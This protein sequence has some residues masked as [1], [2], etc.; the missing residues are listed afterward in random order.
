MARVFNNPVAS[1]GH[2][3]TIADFEPVSLTADDIL[4]HSLSE[5]MPAW[6]HIAPVYLELNQG[7]FTTQNSLIVFPEISLLLD[8]SGLAICCTCAASGLKLCEH[9][10]QVL[11]ALVSRDEYRIFFDKFLRT[12]KFRET[13]ADYGLENELDLDSFFRLEYLQRKLTVLPRQASIL[14]VTAESL[15]AL[16]KHVLAS[17]VVDTKPVALGAL[18]VVFRQHKYYRHL[19][20]E[21]FRAEHTKEGK[22]KNPLLPVL[23][24]DLIWDENDA[25][26]V[27]F[28][29]A[30][31]RFQSPV[32]GEHG[33]TDLAALRA[34]VINPQNLPLY[35]H[36]PDISENTV[37]SSLVPLNISLA[38]IDLQVTVQE[39]SP[40][41]ELGASITIQ[42]I[43]YSLNEVSI[44]FSWFLVAGGRFY[45]IPN[46]ELAAV[47]SLFKKR[48][49]N[50]LVHNSRYRDFKAQILLPLEDKV[51][52]EYTDIKPATQLQLDAYGF[53][54]KPEKII[55]LSDFGDEVMLIPVMRYGEVEISVRTRRQ[56][57]ETDA[58]GTE[59][60]VQRNSEAELTFTSV[61]IRQH[62]FFIEQLENSLDYFYLNKQRFLDDDWFLNVFAEWAE[63]GI[64]VLGFNDLDG[65][66]LSPEKVS[67]TISVLSG[68]NWFNTQVKVRFGKRKASL[69]QVQKAVKNKSRFVQ[70][71]DGTLGILPL[72]WLEKFSA[73]FRSAQIVDEETLRFEKVNFSLVDELFDPQMV[74]RHVREEILSFREK[75][76]DVSS[77][78]A[79]Q[80]PAGFNGVLR[81]Y[82]QEGLNWLNFLDD[83]NFG[84]ILADD[85]G[86]GK[87]VQIIAFI[88]SQR[89]K[90]LQSTNLVVAPTSVITNWETEIRHFAPSLKVLTIYGADRVRTIREF[91]DYDVI[92]TSYGTL[93]SDIR[94]LKDYTFNYIFLDESQQIKNPDSQRNRSVRLL[95]ARNRIAITGTPLENFTTDLYG[96]LAFACPGLLGTRQ[97][98][99]DLYAIPIDRFK[100]NKK[101]TELKEKVR[102]FILRRTKKQVAPELPEKTEMVLYC[103]M[104]PAQRELYD[105]AEKELRD[106]ISAT[107]NEEI[108]KTPM[109]VLRGL[110]RL[111]QLCDSPQL[112]QHDTLNGVASA[113]IDTLMEQLEG[114]IGQHKILIFSQF[115]T[116][117]D[118]IRTEL[119]ARDWKHAYLTGASRKRGAIVSGF[120]SDPEIRIFLIS[121]KAGGTG[122]NLTEAD[123]VYL[124]DPW[125]NPAVENQAVDRSHR[126]GQDKS[127]VAIRLICPGT[128]EEKMML[129]Q[130][131]KRDLADEL[132]QSQNPF[133]KSLDR[134]DL[135]QLLS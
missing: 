71:D 1:A 57:Y 103:E 37:V 94:H 29:T 109:S 82:Q 59:F 100:S 76:A 60:R 49:E 129:L 41:F 74:D 84:G 89:T 105:A 116:M 113:K 9:Q 123:Y 132:I 55:Y 125:W 16:R 88:L 72:A 85:M 18:M 135:L 31:A 11:M 53:S 47:V 5:E 79:V 115:V 33:E 133:L 28:F 92:L 13:A 104:L 52:V 32:K 117:L 26:A 70:L 61:I 38:Q 99:K 95:K 112:L 114:K 111:R 43:S 87:T 46:A 19:F 36:D 42:E 15:S 96:Q 23:P 81:H 97:H 21:L 27:K 128:V 50:L 77:M 106:Y 67:V 107:T 20:I 66:R 44:R 63:Q 98:F 124:V 90:T 10:T 3:L 78:K 12:K 134:D 2:S 130:Q 93:L 65:N 110:T 54:V 118:L 34:I 39:K 35:Y 6:Q 86:L 25:P 56:I 127:I 8:P 62:P 122:L 102:P 131:S 30:I 73:Y 14:P 40:F 121:L 120:Q 69:K 4:F 17:T 83:C 7:L 68:I 126:I 48:A 119:I 91:G 75:L 51:A 64:T 24:L 22:P 101:S 108:R 45:L 80:L 58:R